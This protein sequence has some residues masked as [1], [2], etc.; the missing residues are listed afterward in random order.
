[1]MLHPALNRFLDGFELGCAAIRK[2][3]DVPS[4]AQVSNLASGLGSNIVAMGLTLK[5]LRARANALDAGNYQMDDLPDGVT[6]EDINSAYN[7]ID[8]LVQ[9]FADQK[10]RPQKKVAPPQAPQA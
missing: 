2:V 6:L 8:A 10:P 5:E 4:T 9:Q 1:M 7:T 3:L